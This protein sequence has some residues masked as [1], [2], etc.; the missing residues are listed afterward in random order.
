[1]IVEEMG[2]SFVNLEELKKI[3]EELAKSVDLKDKVNLNDLEYIIG[4]DQSFSGDIVISGSVLLNFKSLKVIKSEISIDKVKFPYIPTFLM[5]R[6]GEP[7]VNSVKKVLK[8]V[9]EKHI[10]KTVIMVD[11][12]GIAHPRRC[13]L[14]TFIALKT[15]VPSIGIT[16][17]RLYGKVV[18]PTKEYE[19]TPILDEVSNDL[20]GYAFKPCKICKPIYISPGSFIST[21]TALEIVKKCMRGYKLPEPIRLAHD[22]VT[23]YKKK[24]KHTGQMKLDF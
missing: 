24:I 3:Q 20:I 9:K 14:A 21:N 16:K 22:I 15:G 7:A 6:E 17:K 8:H 13:G 4:V 5:F 10:E 12:S 11:G 2:S 1:M 19:T 23:S 18:E